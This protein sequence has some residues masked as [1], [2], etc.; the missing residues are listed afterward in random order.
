MKNNYHIIS[1]EAMDGA[2]AKDCLF[3][4][5]Q[6]SGYIQD[7]DWHTVLEYFPLAQLETIP[8]AGHWVHIDARQ[9][10]IKKVFL[11]SGLRLTTGAYILLFNDILAGNNRQ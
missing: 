6:K 7:A 4:R 10:L 1:G 11:I 2:F 3:I 8:H 9:I 5:G